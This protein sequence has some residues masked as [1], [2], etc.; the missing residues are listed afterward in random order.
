MCVHIHTRLGIVCF[1]ISL[2]SWISAFESAQI[3]AIALSCVVHFAL[4]CFE[5]RLRCVVCVCEWVSFGLFF[6]LANKTKKTERKK[7]YSLS[8][9][10]KLQFIWLWVV[11]VYFGGCVRFSRWTHFFGAGCLGGFAVAFASV[12]CLLCAWCFVCYVCALCVCWAFS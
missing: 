12:V 2:W 3:F 10:I 4:H 8:N 7:I 11:S 6:R 9:K 5:L 1:N